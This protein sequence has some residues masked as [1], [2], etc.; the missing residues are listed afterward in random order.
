MDLESTCKIRNTMPKKPGFL[1]I[2]IEEQTPNIMMDFGILTLDDGTAYQND[3]AKERIFLL[4]RGEAIIRVED[5]K[6]NI[7][8]GNIYDEGPWTLHVPMDVKVEI[9]GVSDNTEFAVHATKNNNIFEIKLY[10]PEDCRIEIRGAGQ[11]NEAGTRLVRTIID[12]A[13]APYANLMLGEDVHYPGKWAG[14]PSHS[15]AQPEIYFYRFLPDQGFGLLK[16]GDQGICLENNDTVLIL[17]GLVHPQVAAPGYAMYFLWVIR[18][19]EGN[20]YIRPD[21]EEKHLWVEA[22]GAEIW[23]E[24]KGS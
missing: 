8:R 1:P 18:H 20:P 16:L 19:L 22:P 3:D 14:F 6:F 12:H 4:L 11:M 7:K 21:F 17:P 24:R 15:H 9:E 13:N 5:K 10:R 23:P 2:V